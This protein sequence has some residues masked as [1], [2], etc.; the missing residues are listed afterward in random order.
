MP[1]GEIQPIRYEINSS[2][3]NVIESPTRSA[4]ACT[5]RFDLPLSFIKK[6]KAD[7]RLATIS[8][9][10]AATNIFIGKFV[11]SNRTY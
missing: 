4:S 10:A 6:N 5:V 2:A 7:A 11:G 8:R 9:N 1:V 3:N